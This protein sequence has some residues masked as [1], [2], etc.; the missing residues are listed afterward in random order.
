M[1]P[2]SIRDKIKESVPFSNQ[3]TTSNLN[4]MVNTW[5]ENRVA[6]EDA[7]KQ[8]PSERFGFGEYTVRFNGIDSHVSRKDNGEYRICIFPYERSLRLDN[9]WYK[10][11]NNVSYNGSTITNHSVLIHDYRELE[12][13]EAYSW[14]YDTFID[15]LTFIATSKV[16]SC[17]NKTMINALV[18]KH[19]WYSINDGMF[20]AYGS[21]PIPKHLTYYK[22]DCWSIMSFDD[23]IENYNIDDIMDVKPCKDPREDHW[24]HFVRIEHQLEINAKEKVNNYVSEVFDKVRNHE[25]IPIEARAAL[26]HDMK[27]VDRFVKIRKRYKLITKHFSTDK[28]QKAI[29]KERKNIDNILFGLYTGKL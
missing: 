2:T 19:K 1:K 15:I 26:I 11:Y 20:Y 7:F 14:F 3:S 10:L 29:D 8:Q 5:I 4:G 27:D 17:F 25:S 22:F 28:L 18:Y 13:I 23:I 9:P 12:D 16:T 21:S 6:I 24:E